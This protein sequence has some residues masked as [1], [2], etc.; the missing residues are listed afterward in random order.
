MVTAGPKFVENKILKNV[1]LLPSIFALEHL[2][3]A[4]L[5]VFDRDAVQNSDF[6]SSL[7]AATTDNMPS[8]MTSLF[9]VNQL[10]GDNRTIVLRMENITALLRYFE[11]EVILTVVVADS[12][13][14]SRNAWTSSNKSDTMLDT[15]KDKL[16]DR[17]TNRQKDRLTEKQT[18]KQTD[19]STD[20]Q[21]DRQTGIQ[22]DRHTDRQTDR[23]TDRLITAN[24]NSPLA[25]SAAQ[26]HIKFHPVWP[27]LLRATSDMNDLSPDAKAFM[28]QYPVALLI[29]FGSMICILL[30]VILAMAAAYH[31]VKARRLNR[32]RPFFLPGN[33]GSCSTR[34]SIVTSPITLTALPSESHA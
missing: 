22:I 11:S 12:K 31:R 25:C 19:R 2:E 29:V 16:T 4:Q 24:V 1:D 10:E 18:E 3:I 9:T 28:A 33:S 7:E 14:T 20:R 5:T 32:I 15:G 27:G 34:S 8:Q 13:R 21:T 17:Q 23:Q 6:V 26:V 30:L